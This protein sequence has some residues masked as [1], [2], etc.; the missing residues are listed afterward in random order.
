M[1]TATPLVFDGA[2]PFTASAQRRARLRLL[3]A[4]LAVYVIWGSTYYAVRIALGGFSPLWLTGIRFSVAGAALYAVA[5][6]RGARRPTPRQLRN[7]V[8]VGLLLLVGGNVPIVIAEQWVTSGLAAMVAATMPLF[9]A[10]IGAMTGERPRRREVLGLALGFLGVMTLSGAGGLGGAP[11]KALIVMAAP[12]SWALGSWVARRIELP[13]GLVATSLEM[14]GAGSV[15]LVGA[16]AT[17][18]P[19]RVPS[20]LPVLGLVYLTVFGSIVAFSAFGYLLSHARPALATSHAYVNPVV[21]VLLGA[22]FGEPLTAT[23]LV[24]LVAIVA[25]VLVMSRARRAA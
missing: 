4:L 19:L 11:P 17:G 5:R 24:S 9:A 8:L 10:A 15:L 13:E 23:S 2:A 18:E 12:L 6:A 21:A 1:A 3:L 14:L 25:G 16:I 22:A 7:A 20:L